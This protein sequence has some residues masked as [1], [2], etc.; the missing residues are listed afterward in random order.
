MSQR[1]VAGVCALALFAGVAAGWR[2]PPSPLW[3]AWSVALALAAVAVF[4]TDAL[5]ALATA[6]GRRVVVALA[7]LT[8]FIGGLWSHFAV[9]HD[10]PRYDDETAYLL[11]ARIFAHG[12]AW[13]TDVP[14]A[15]MLPHP[16]VIN[17]PDHFA[18]AML[19]G[20]PLVLAL[21]AALGA[22]WIVSPVLAALAVWLAA[23]A[24]ADGVA[25]P[26]EAHARAALAAL[27]VGTSPWVAL[28]A[29]SGFGHVACLA[30]TFAAVLGARRAGS[31]RI[32]GAIALALLTFARP[33][34]GLV[35]GACLAAA[36]LAGDARD[37]LAALVRYA[38]A[39]ALPLGLLLVWNRALTGHALRFPADAW[40]DAIDRVPGC[41]RMG[42]GARIG[43]PLHARN[44]P[45][46]FP[47]DGLRV[48][49]LRLGQ[50]ARD[51]LGWSLALAWLVPALARSTPRATPV[52][53]LVGAVGA[54]TVAAYAGFYYHGIA[55]GSRFYFVLLAPLALGLAAA[56]APLA[57]RFVERRA[58]ADGAAL[59]LAL[60]PLVASLAITAAPAPLRRWRV[61]DAGL[62]ALRERAADLRNAVV[63]VDDEDTFHAVHNAT[64]IDGRGF[65]GPVRYVLDDLHDAHLVATYFAGAH[66]YRW[67]AAARVLRP[68][69]APAEGAIVRIPFQGRW[70]LWDLRD[71]SCPIG[72]G[73]EP[74][75]ECLF[76]A[77]GAEAAT[78]EHLRGGTT[79]VAARVVHRRDGATVRLTVDGH[80]VGAAL[81]TATPPFD[82]VTTSALATVTLTPGAHRL[83]FV[84][85]AGSPAGARFSVAALLL[86]SP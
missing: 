60:V 68:E 33:L 31:W 66:L 67:D 45:G 35:V 39:L 30:L 26:A 85:A 76:W 27:I 34:D 3:L 28:Q 41:H 32:A 36:A 29:G 7:A 75:L 20:W 56:L 8:A 83:G 48:T 6:R 82:V 10:L 14:F 2:P 46:F 64:P 59:A 86:R 52:L 72:H 73:A 44:L 58:T 57:A 61:P 18:G 79:T 49:G 16:L 21:G 24:A 65:A 50:L 9:L 54:L 71:A 53:R 43:C 17:R 81:D 42:F 51:L 4:R 25:D 47:L 13:L 22:P 80:A 70:P 84:A 1:A 69:A 77:P 63:L 37:R 15:S 62:H 12:R 55:Y 38:L 19:P 11:Q 40:F 5:T 74:T 78:T 23:E